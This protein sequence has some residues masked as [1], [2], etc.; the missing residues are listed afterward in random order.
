[1]LDFAFFVLFVFILE[2][3]AVCQI[4]NGSEGRSGA[5][6]LV[7]P[8]EIKQRFNHAVCEMVT[9]LALSLSLSL[10]SSSALALF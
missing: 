2:V 9:S 8:W 3:W 7:T 4:E 10:F 6:L 1:M 5:G